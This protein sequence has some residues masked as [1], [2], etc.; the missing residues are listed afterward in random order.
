VLAILP[1][2]PFAIALINWLVLLLVAPRRMLRM[3]Y[4]GGIPVSSCTLVVVPT[5]LTSLANVEGLLEVLEARFLANRDLHL[6]FGLLADLP[7]L[8]A[9][10]LEQDA[11]LLA[12]TQAGIETLNERTMR[13]AGAIPSF[14]SIGRVAGTL[15]TASG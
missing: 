15:K 1:G 5:L 12:L 10:T 11:H 9:E 14:C 7:D 3:D 6:H 2:G 4:S 8:L 13:M